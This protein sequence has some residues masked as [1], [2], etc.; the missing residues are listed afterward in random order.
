MLTAIDMG[1]GK[2]KWSIPLGTIKRYGITIP[3]SWGWGSPNVGGPIVTAGGLIFI[4]ATMDEQFRALDLASGK[5][6]WAADLPAPGM[7]LPMTYMAGGRQYVVIAAGGSTR[8][9]TDVDDSLIAYA[10]PRK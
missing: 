1:T 9:G 7:A 5:Q 6:L 10:L 2:T 4:G 8:V 3:Q